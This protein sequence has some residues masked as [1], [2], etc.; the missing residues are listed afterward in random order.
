M[1]DCTNYTGCEG[2]MSASGLSQSIW[3]NALDLDLIVPLAVA[4]LVVRISL[5]LFTNYTPQW[6]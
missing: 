1:T 5:T 6:I 3:S 4:V 2:K